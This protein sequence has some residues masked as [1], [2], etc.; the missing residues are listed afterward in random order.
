MSDAAIDDIKWWEN[1]AK[2]YHKNIGQIAPSNYI[3]TDALDE[4]WG[5]HSGDAN[6]GGKW[7]IQER[8]MCINEKDL[9][10]VL[11]GLRVLCSSQSNVT[12]LIKSDNMTTV[13]YINKQKQVGCKSS[14]LN[15]IGV[16]DFGQ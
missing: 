14:V 5:A 7:P 9:L 11:E 13:S 16:S 12:L 3:T 4:G 2:F 1:Q 8:G 6:S 10:A 15:E